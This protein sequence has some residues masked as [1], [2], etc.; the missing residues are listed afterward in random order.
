MVLG[1]MFGSIRLCL[2]SEYP[3]DGFIDE[4]GDLYSKFKE[5]KLF[6]NKLQF[7]GKLLPKLSNNFVLEEY[8]DFGTVSHSLISS[9][10]KKNYLYV[11]CER[12]GI[13]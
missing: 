12:R 8:F 9:K 6:I 10:F 4:F 3:V 7:T 11:F 2:R 1:D 13:L 5:F